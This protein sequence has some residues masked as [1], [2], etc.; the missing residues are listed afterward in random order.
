MLHCVYGFL[1]K[2][3]EAWLL[4][5]GHWS[6]SFCFEMQSEDFGIVLSH[7]EIKPSI[8]FLTHFITKKHYTKERWATKL[9]LCVCGGCPDWQMTSLLRLMKLTS[10]VVRSSFAKI[11]FFDI[12]SD[13][14]H[15]SVALLDITKPKSWAAKAGKLQ[16]ACFLQ[17]SREL[18]V[19]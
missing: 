2:I 16:P 6:T 12:S 14:W 9:Y 4:M 19:A 13:T 1:P 7:F 8:F 17:N 15:F 5:H 18:Y 10:G 3:A 11:I